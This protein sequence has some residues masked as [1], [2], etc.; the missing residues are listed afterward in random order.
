MT[1]SRQGDWTRATAQDK[2]P[3]VRRAATV[4]RAIARHGRMTLTG[5]AD[6]TAL[7]KSTLFYLVGALTSLDFLQFDEASKT[8][9]LGVALVELGVAAGEQMTELGVAKRYLAELLEL[10]GMTITIS[11]RLDVHHSLLIDKI[12]R[13]HRPRITFPLGSPVSILTGAA[14][15]AFLAF[16]DDA[17]VD[18]ALTA[19]LPQH[20]PL[21][22]T[23]PEVFRMELAT[24]R[25]TGWTI[26]REGYILGVT[27]IS[28]PVF[29]LD[30]HVKLVGSAV[31]FSGAF[32]D[33]GIEGFGA[34]LR[35]TCDRIGQ[36]LSGGTIPGPE[37][38]PWLEKDVLAGEA[39]ES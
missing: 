16:D 6:E 31:G 38:K 36:V 4:L 20:T 37:T 26:D 1:R 10:P 25:R 7:N 27:T 39:A 15:R 9:T 24:A 34:V 3:A 17:T 12:E 21:S 19:G 32:D 5:L 29:D 30:G 18:E 2:V 11:T 35:N 28:A 22:V 14:G 23:D 8:Y 33:P 13:L